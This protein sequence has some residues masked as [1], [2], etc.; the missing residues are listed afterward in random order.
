[1]S[2]PDKTEGLIICIY[3]TI[4]LD[5]Y[6]KTEYFICANFPKSEFSALLKTCIFPN[7]VSSLRKKELHI[8]SKH[9]FYI[10][11][12]GQSSLS[13][14]HSSCSKCVEKSAI[15]SNILFYSHSQHLQASMNISIAFRRIYR[16]MNKSTRLLIKELQ[17]TVQGAIN[18][19]QDEN[20]V[21][22]PTIV[23]ATYTASGIV[24]MIKAKHII[25]TFLPERIDLE[26]NNGMFPTKSIRPTIE[27]I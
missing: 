8:F 15:R 4:R 13:F 27:F 12:N 25:N 2:L 7:N 26:V 23:A 11:I 17:N 19:N 1:M 20:S 9:I 22:F 14:R 10:G 24:R 21:S 5:T 3:N 16:N 6:W 18:L